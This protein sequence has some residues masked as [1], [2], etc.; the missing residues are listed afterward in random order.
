MDIWIGLVLKLG[1]FRWFTGA[2]YCWR[3]EIPAEELMGKERAQETES[4]IVGR[5]GGVVRVGVPDSGDNLAVLFG[6]VLDWSIGGGM[7]ET[8]TERRDET[9]VGRGGTGALTPDA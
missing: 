6:R 4:S 8:E 2:A 1:K 5:W 3:S 9:S 7:T